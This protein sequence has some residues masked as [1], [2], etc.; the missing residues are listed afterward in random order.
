M[1]IRISTN[2]FRQVFFAIMALLTSI[3][4][5]AE[6][7]KE[8]SPTS[9]F[10]TGLA[11]IPA[12]GYGSYLGVTDDNRIKFQIKDASTENLYMGFKWTNYGTANDV[13]VYYKIYN[14]AGAV[15]QSGS[16]TNT[17]AGSI[18][19]YAQAVEGPNIAGTAPTGYA[20]ISF[21]PAANGEYYI[22]FFR[23]SDGGVTMNNTLNSQANYFDLT[24]ATAT[25]TR[26]RGESKL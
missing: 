19:T 15:V 20:P 24:V 4:L 16:F 11:L 18:S 17:G 1:K 6:G 8:T 13:R 10:L 22:V 9:T 12:S 21:D 3:N 5:L 7:T 2:Y 14:P 26:Y 25:G 23:S